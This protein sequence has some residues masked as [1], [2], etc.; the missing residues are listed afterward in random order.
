MTSNNDPRFK[1]NEKF[2]DLNSIKINKSP[3]NIG[4]HNSSRDEEILKPTFDNINDYGGNSVEESRFENEAYAK[5][6]ENKIENTDENQEDDSSSERNGYRIS[7]EVYGY[8][9]IYNPNEEQDSVEEN[10]DTERESV[11]APPVKR[12]RRDEEEYI[13]SFRSASLESLKDESVDDGVSVLHMGTG[14]QTVETG[15]NMQNKIL[16][17]RKSKNSNGVRM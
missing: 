13:E 10:D 8:Q 12:I 4:F 16:K 3:N 5:V 1:S 6:I 7:E 15:S 14:S 17:P 11:K 2:P 9:G